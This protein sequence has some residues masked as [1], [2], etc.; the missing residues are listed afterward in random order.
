MMGAAKKERFLVR[1]IMGFCILIT[2]LM[3]YSV[4]K[5][6]Q[7]DRTETIATAV[8]SNANLA[9]ALEQ[10]AIG[11]IRNADAV[12]QLVKKEYALDPKPDLGRLLNKYAFAKELF[13]M[14]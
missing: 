5:Q 14:V 9:A 3:W 10:Y 11:T 12:I 7:A 1:G 2:G 13:T 8:E 6:L 4:Q